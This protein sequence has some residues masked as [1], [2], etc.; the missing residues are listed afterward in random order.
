LKEARQAVQLV[1]PAAV[2]LDILLKG[3][4]AWTYLAELRDDPATRKIPVLVVTAVADQHKAESLGAD[5]YAVKPVEKRWLTAQ[6]QRLT[7][8]EPERKV[9]V[10]DDDE[11]SRYLL[12]Q[13][14]SPGY[15]IFEA[16]SGLEGIRR[17]CEEAPQLV[18]LD[19][20]MP[21][22]TGFEV[23]KQLQADPRTRDIPIVVFTS[24][25]LSVE[26]RRQI[27]TAAAV[28]PKAEA[29]RDGV[30][31]A[32]RRALEGGRLATSA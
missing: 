15:A 10:V 11:L 27:E 17:A 24:R 4:D 1:K 23:L 19:L 5:A 32:V 18:I 26:E 13:F 28:L 16:Q 7:S 6:L 21:G 31:E 22:M 3:E 9:L 8:K 25:D 14:L 12:R 30:L 2:I 29:T 20:T